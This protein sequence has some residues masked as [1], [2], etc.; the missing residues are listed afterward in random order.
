MRIEDL[1]AGVAFKVGHRI[2]TVV[3]RNGGGTFTLRDAADGHVARYRIPAEPPLPRLGV[4]GAG[5]WPA[6]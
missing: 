4:A 1:E 2:F 5:R 3:E 6:L